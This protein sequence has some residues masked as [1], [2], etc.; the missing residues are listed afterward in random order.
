M[1][2]LDYFS[3]LVSNVEER[4]C[5]QGESVLSLFLLILYSFHPVP[6]GVGLESGCTTISSDWHHHVLWLIG[7]YTF[8]IK[9]VTPKYLHK[10]VKMNY[11]T[12][13]VV[14]SNPCSGFRWLQDKST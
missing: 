3:T 4:V 8:K 14:S 11:K 2:F 5:Y 9:E 12:Q 7:Q 13:Q 10:A 6:W 1:A